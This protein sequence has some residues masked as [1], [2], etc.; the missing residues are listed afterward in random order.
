MIISSQTVFRTDFFGPI[1]V[2]ESTLTLISQKLR[3]SHPMSP[4]HKKSQE[5]L[6]GWKGKRKYGEKEQS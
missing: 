6:D 1:Q 4:Y 2:F 3:G 5:G